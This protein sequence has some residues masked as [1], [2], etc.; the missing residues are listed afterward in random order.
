MRRRLRSGSIATSAA[1]GRIRDIPQGD[2]MTITERFT[3]VDAN[4]INYTVTID[5]SKVYTKPWTVLPLN[6]DDTYQMFEY[7]CEEGNN[8][9]ANALSSAASA[10]GRWHNPRRSRSRGRPG[11]DVI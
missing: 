6:R 7:S 8:E 3:R 9:M 10:I 5:D 4:T 2:A 1:T 11:V